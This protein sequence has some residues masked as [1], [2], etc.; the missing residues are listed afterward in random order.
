MITTIAIPLYMP[1]ISR[2]N[3]PGIKLFPPD[4]LEYKLLDVDITI[5]NK[6]NKNEFDFILSKNKKI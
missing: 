2:N 4:K 3:I 5:T 1:I 6:T